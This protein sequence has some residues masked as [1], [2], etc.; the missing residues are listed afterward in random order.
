MDPGQRFARSLYSP[1]STPPSQ[2]QPRGFRKVESAGTT[3]PAAAEKD[4]YPSPRVDNPQT[5][6]P[7]GV[8]RHPAVAEIAHLHRRNG[9]DDRTV[10]RV[11]YNAVALYLVW[12]FT[13]AVRDL[14]TKVLVS[15][16]AGDGDA[17]EQVAAPLWITLLPYA[18]A[19]LLVFNLVEAF[20]RFVR[21]GAGGGAAQVLG[22]DAELEM[23]KRGVVL[24]PQQRKVLNLPESASP[25]DTPR[26]P[27]PQP[28]TI[29]PPRYQRNHSP[30][31]ASTTH[32]TVD[33]SPLRRQSHQSPLSLGSRRT[34]H[35]DTSTMTTTTTTTTDF[36]GGSARWR[37]S[38]LA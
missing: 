10:R 34:S 7:T 30:S 31:P 23:S 25:S 35:N 24:T 3:T 33:D 2:L 38:Q 17:I 26:S 36:G 32:S 20:S 28:R 5:S 11:L 12:R 37:Y 4:R 18:V 8:W 22:E 21:V 9:A 15:R 14:I 27:R 6:T 16:P 13:P 29:T 1:G 19:G